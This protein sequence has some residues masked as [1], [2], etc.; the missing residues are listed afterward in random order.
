MTYLAGLLTGRICMLNGV[1]SPGPGVSTSAPD[2]DSVNAAVAS[3]SARD[4]A[5]NLDALLAEAQ[6]AFWLVG[7]AHAK[8]QPELCEGVLSANLAGRERS[9]IEDACKNKRSF[10]PRD[11]DAKTG[12]LL[13]ISTDASGDTVTVHFT[14]TWGPVA[15]RG[16]QERRVQNWCFH[17]P[18]S[19]RTLPAEAGQRCANCGGAL[20]SSTGT[21][22]Y[23]GTLIGSGNGWRVIRIDDVSASSAAEAA[24]TM[25]TIV[26]EI[27]AARRADGP[28]PVATP[29]RPRRRVRGLAK[30]LFFLVLAGAA[31]VSVAAAGSGRLHRDVANVLPFTRHPELVA[32]LDLSGQVSATNVSALQKPPLVEFGGNCKTYSDRTSWDFRAKLP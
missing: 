31:L 7:Q 8:C 1:T 24:A 3:I 28:V 13:S 32:S 2:A 5:F 29:G 10:A 15:G 19:A 27:M 4:A 22:R 20:S 26:D 25:R 30:P 18:A 16:N 11:E 23:C 21:C 17:R 9:A 6:Q 14:S 12:Q